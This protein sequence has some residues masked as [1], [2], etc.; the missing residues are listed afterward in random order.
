MK[1]T[2]LSFFI[3]IIGIIV[4]SFINISTNEVISTLT[5][6]FIYLALFLVLYF[7][8]N[9]DYKKKITLE[10]LKYTAIYLTIGCIL[11][12]IS[13]NIINKII[14]LPQNEIALREISNAHPIRFLIS[15]LIYSPLIEEILF[16]HN[17]NFIKNKYLYLIITSALF[18]ILHINSK[19]ELLYL[20][21]YTILGLIFGLTYKKS[22]N[23][24][25]STLTHS[26]YNLISFIILII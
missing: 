7:I 24:L 17:F 13:T 9:I 16:R 21:P 5:Y 4:Y 18:A 3:Y 11:I 22:D 12:Y 10:D 8:N 1:K 19:S 2:L 26:T 20:I 25:L 6:I 14:D 23:L 15:I